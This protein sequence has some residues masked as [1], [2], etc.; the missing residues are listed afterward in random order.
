MVNAQN[1]NTYSESNKK[2]YLMWF[3]TYVNVHT[4]TYNYQMEGRPLGVFQT[5]NTINRKVECKRGIPK[6]KIFVDTKQTY[7]MEK[8]IHEFLKLNFAVNL[9]KLDLN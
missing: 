1:K 8:L 4:R 9:P 5:F 6:C 7:N 3:I 2:Q